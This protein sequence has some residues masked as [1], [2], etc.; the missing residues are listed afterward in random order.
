MLQFQYISPE[1]QEKSEKS[2]VF[3][4]H[5]IIER[6]N[7]A[8]FPPGVRVQLLYTGV[9]LEAYEPD[10]A[11]WE[12][13][14]DLP[15]KRESLPEKTK[16]QPRVDQRTGKTYRP[17]ATVSVGKPPISPHDGAWLWVDKFD[18]NPYAPSRSFHLMQ[19]NVPHTEGMHL[20]HEVG[21]STY[22]VTLEVEEI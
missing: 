1:L 7:S 3:D 21:P 9:E 20:L 16:L 22:H 11:A 18:H 17:V 5:H 13:R 12:L 6:E 2:G 8:D 14:L 15:E 10:F 4:G 19:E